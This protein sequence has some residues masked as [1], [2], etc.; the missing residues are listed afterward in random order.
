MILVV[1]TD[2]VDRTRSVRRWCEE[3]QHDDSQLSS[4]TQQGYLLLKDQIAMRSSC[5]FNRNS[6]EILLRLQR[7]NR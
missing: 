3:L 1:Q 2:A 7:F 5:L 4:D 6:L